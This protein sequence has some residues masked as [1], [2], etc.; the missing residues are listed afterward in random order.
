MPPE[1][2]SP[3]EAVKVV[4]TD[5]R[6]AIIFIPGIGRA[7]DDPVIEG[8][9]RRMAT[10]ID[11]ISITEEAQTHVE[12]AE[13]KYGAEYKSKM[14]TIVKKQEGTA[15]PLIDVFGLDYNSTLVESYANRPLFVKMPLLAIT[16]VDSF[17]RLLFRF[18]EKGKGWKEK[19]QFLYG[20]LIAALLFAY[21]VIL[22]FAVVAA[23]QQ[24]WKTPA[25]QPNASAPASATNTQRSQQD[26]LLIQQSQLG[27][28]TFEG[29]WSRTKNLSGRAWTRIRNISNRDFQALVV[30]M[31][32]LGFVLPTKARLK[33]NISIAATNYLC[34]IHYLR[35]GESS[36]A[37]GGKLESLLE[38]IVERKPRYQRIHIIG[39][40]FGSIVAMDNLFP[41]GR[42]PIDR[43][44]RIDT[45]ITIGCPFDI[46]RTYW[47][48]Y[49]NERQSVSGDAMKWINVYSPIDVL[50]SNFADGGN[51]QPFEQART[52]GIGVKVDGQILKPESIEFSER[53][54]KSLG[55]IDILR[56][57][58]FK[59]HSHYWGE[60][61]KG[62]ITCFHHVVKSMY[63]D[64]PVLN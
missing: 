15:R 56:L 23:F 44:K 39:Y 10:A 41:M 7:W 4:E 61:P 51:D 64:T 53:S 60:S 5:E 29:L 36:H 20:L 26:A 38:F 48:S 63:K 32:G 31:A 21:F 59:A 62:E 18:F 22:I 3:P 54:H 50:S 52:E 28:A 30:L 40:S 42:P 58:G 55:V 8:V 9:A 25:P 43:F 34:L 46:I 49:F 24:L 6:E 57:A 14:F 16:T 19:L 45:L 2:S 35:W 33:E 17:C 47:P 1:L 13:L 12:V 11:R 27:G 37:I